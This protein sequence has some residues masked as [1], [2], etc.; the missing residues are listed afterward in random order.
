MTTIKV[1]DIVTYLNNFV[2]PALAYH[3][4]NVGFQLGDAN[5]DVNKILLTLD[6][7][8]N[9]INKAIEQNC[10]MIISHHPFIFK[11]IKKITNPNYIR[12]IKHNIAVYCAH[13]NLDVINGGVNSV[14]AHKL[15]LEIEEFISEESGSN[16]LQIAVYVPQDSA[17]IVANA[18]LAAGAGRIGNYTHCLASSLVKGQFMPNENSNPTIG[19]AN[20][21]ETISEV[22]L[23]FFVDSILL[24]KVLKALKK[25]H[26]YETPVYAIYPQ[27]NSSNFGLGVIGNLK[28]P[29][30]MKNFAQSVKQQLNAPTISLW[31]AQKDE[32]MMIKKVAICGGS[33]SSLLNKLHGRADIFVSAD[34]TYH[35]IL[36]SRIPLIDA[37]H[38]Y[39]ENPAL[40]ILEEV[41]AEFECEIIK[42]DFNEH[43]ISKMINI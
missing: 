28:E 36:D 24:T 25:A 34:F 14:L 26:P 9:A 42:L 10:D 29:K 27:G 17:E 4:D 32:N 1:S 18:V 30:T 39:T 41:L 40:D 33:G 6:V 7:T 31:P 21:L 8:E 37:G 2:N 15:G 38:F 13:T 22:K 23:E 11:P 20:K 3:W 19:E 43:E 16:S 5:N 35:T 12:L